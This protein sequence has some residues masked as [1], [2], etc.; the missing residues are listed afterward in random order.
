MRDMDSEVDNHI[1]PV[2][3]SLFDSMMRRVDGIMLLNDMGPSKYDSEMLG[4]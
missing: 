4:V 1:P 3:Y 2:D